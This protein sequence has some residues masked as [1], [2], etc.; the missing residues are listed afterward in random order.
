[1]TILEP[2]QAI[3]RIVGVSTALISKVVGLIIIGVGVTGP[4]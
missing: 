1:M 3:R 2:N 4:A